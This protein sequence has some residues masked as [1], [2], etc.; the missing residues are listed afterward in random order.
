M[1]KSALNLCRT[2]SLISVLVLTGCP[3]PEGALGEFEARKAEDTGMTMMEMCKA[4]DYNF[5]PNPAIDTLCADSS[6]DGHGLYYARLSTTLARKVPLHFLVEIGEKDNESF[7]NLTPISTQGELIKQ[8]L[9]ENTL[10][11]NADGTFVVNTGDVDVN[12]LANPLSGSDILANLIL[13]GKFVTGGGLCGALAGCLIRPYSYDL[14]GSTFTLIP[15]A[16]ESAVPS[17]FARTVAVEEME[18]PTVCPAPPM[19]DADTDASSDNRGG[20]P[21]DGDLTTGGTMM[22]AVGGSAASGG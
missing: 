8:N 4:P 1:V 13:E 3:D 9:I 21:D 19:A 6:R 16:D 17:E 11:T 7:F 20:Q 18:C 5:T 10:T 14:V 15:I 22:D 2:A 12:G